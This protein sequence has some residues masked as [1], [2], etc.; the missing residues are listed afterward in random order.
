MVREDDIDQ[1]AAMIRTGS[2]SFHSA[3][4]LLP[5]RIRKPA[6]VLYA[7]CRVA[8]DEVDLTMG[9]T[10][11]VARL[12]DRL[13]KCYDGRPRNCPQDRAFA[14]LVNDYEIPKALP[15]ALLDG[16]AWD[17]RA[18]RYSD[19]A[20]LR[21]Y[22]A[23]VAAAVG[24]MMCLL[25]RVRDRHTLARACDLGV[26]MQLTNIARDVGE[27]AREGRLY[28]PLDW[29]SEAGIEPDAFLLKPCMTT[30]LAEVVDR[31]LT[32]AG[33]LYRRSDQGVSGLPLSCRPGIF[34]ASRIYEAIGQDLRRYS[35]DAINRR[36]RTTRGQKLG[37]LGRALLDAGVSVVLPRLPTMYTP[38]L[39]EVSF[40][41]DAAATPARD[42]SDAI[43]SILAGLKARDLK[44]R[45]TL[46]EM[47]PRSKFLA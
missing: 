11:A 36:A 19:I 6:F 20:E 45:A 37:W 42:R 39:A 15:E 44:Q 46:H 38:P 5:D 43:L 24:V 33:K 4:R 9:K 29:L 10:A 2:H 34:A 22:S 32:E 35:F 17:A 1:C 14:M 41:V 26:A 18:R 7:F 21:A 16:L 13:D 40:L 47:S 27:D 3:S 23:R 31:L 25:M 30:E 12:Q 8:D 28:L